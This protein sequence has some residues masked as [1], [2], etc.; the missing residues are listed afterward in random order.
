MTLHTSHDHYSR[1]SHF[2]QSCLVGHGPHTWLSWLSH[3]KSTMTLTKLSRLFWL[4][5]VELTMTLIQP[6]WL[7]SCWLMPVWRQSRGTGTELRWPAR[8]V[9]DRVSEPHRWHH[10]QTASG[11]AVNNV[12]DF[13][14]TNICNNVHNQPVQVYKMIIKHTRR[15]VYRQNLY[16]VYINV[17]L[18]IIWYRF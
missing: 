8:H 15:R 16:Q 9:H 7:E 5:R 3:I 1:I 2:H 12:I 14:I 18:K 17:W 4:S 10:C 11:R 13:V 6:S